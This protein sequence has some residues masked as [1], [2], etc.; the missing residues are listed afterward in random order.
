MQQYCFDIASR[1]LLYG[2]LVTRIVLLERLCPLVA[3]CMRHVS[4]GAVKTGHP[5]PWARSRHPTAQKTCRKR[6]AK[7]GNNQSTDARRDLGQ[8]AA[9]NQNEQCARLLLYKRYRTLTGLREGLVDFL[10]PRSLVLVLDAVLLR[11][12][13]FLWHVKAFTAGM[14]DGCEERVRGFGATNSSSNRGLLTYSVTSVVA[15]TM[16][17][18]ISRGWFEVM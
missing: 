9:R 4:E 15:H 11:G 5:R 2:E 7:N 14:R 16:I 6:K 3:R 10:D 1:R 8:V 17:N 18:S 13:Q 12:V